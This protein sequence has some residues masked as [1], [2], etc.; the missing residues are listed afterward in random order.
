M[1]RFVRFFDLLPQYPNRRNFRKMLSESSKTSSMRLINW[2]SLPA[3]FL[4]ISSVFPPIS[5]QPFCFSQKK[6]TVAKPQSVFTII[7]ILTLLPI[8]RWYDHGI[9]QVFWL[10]WYRIQLTLSVLS[11]FPKKYFQWPLINVDKTPCS[12]RRDRA[13]LSPASLLAARFNPNLRRT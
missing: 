9:M 12:Q 2:L 8:P 4:L 7:N 6:R 11:A 3:F 10:T 13:G 1:R 5:F